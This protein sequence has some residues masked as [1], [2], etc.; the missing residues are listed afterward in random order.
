MI[1]FLAIFSYSLV[2]YW[3]GKTKKVPQ[4]STLE[5]VE[6]SIKTLATI[7]ATRK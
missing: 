7:L 4:N 3:L 6:F 5:L 2:E 1:T